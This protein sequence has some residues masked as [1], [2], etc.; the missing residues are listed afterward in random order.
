MSEALPSLGYVTDEK[1]MTPFI[2]E[3][4][5]YLARDE[6]KGT[7]CKSCGKKYFPPRDRCQC[8]S[9][10]GMEWIDVA[11]SGKLLTFSFIDEYGMPP[12]SMQN[13]VPYVVAVAGLDD[14]LR[15]LCHLTGIADLPQ[16]GMPVKLTI[17][18]LDDGARITYR[19]VPA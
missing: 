9:K 12:A 10:E 1:C 4:V 15:I 2:E 14:G 5:R 6:I 7:M 13:R 19:L 18:V 11:R 17:Q 3:F 8:Q 16:V